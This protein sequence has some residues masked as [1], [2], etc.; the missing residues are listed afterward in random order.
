MSI[1]SINEK[2]IAE[3]KLLCAMGYANPVAILGEEADL[4]NSSLK[5]WQDAILAGA[6]DE[7]LLEMGKKEISQIADTLT[8][9]LMVSVYERE[10]C[11]PED[12]VQI[13]GIEFAMPENIR[14]ILKGYCLDYGSKRFILR[15]SEGIVRNLRSIKRIEP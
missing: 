2:A 4:P 11:Q 10:D 7:D 15:S 13:D 5:G 12:I 9:Y 14:D 8:Y 1:F 6:S 3:I